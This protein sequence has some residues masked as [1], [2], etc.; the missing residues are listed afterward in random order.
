MEST[1]STILE[2]YTVLSMTTRNGMVYLSG[3]QNTTIPA[4]KKL[5]AD[6]LETVVEMDYPSMVRFT[7]TVL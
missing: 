3:L 7:V 4:F 5:R 2:G 6:T 1:N